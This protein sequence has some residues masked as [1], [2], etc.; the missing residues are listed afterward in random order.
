MNGQD[1]QGK[2]AIVT[3]GVRGLGRA[4]AEL[5]AANGASVVIADVNGDAGNDFAST[6]GGNALYQH[7]DV[8]VSRTAK[9]WWTGSGDVPPA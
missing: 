6:L 2:V 8:S 9:R 1:L 7:T 4:V 5:F 3:G